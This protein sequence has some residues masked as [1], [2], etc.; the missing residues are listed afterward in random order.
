MGRRPGVARS[1]WPIAATDL[2]GLAGQL[3]VSLG[4]VPFRKPW[5]GEGNVPHNLAV[6]VTRET[7]RSFM[8]YLTAL[9]IDEFRSVELVLDD[10]S[11]AVL[12]PV[13][14]SLDVDQS[15][16]NVAGVPG[17]WY[18]P[19]GAAARGT[20]LYL[21]GGGYVGT[22]PRMYAVFVAWLCRQ[23]GCELFVADLRLAPEFP[24]PAGLEDA[25]LVVEGL[26]AAGTNPDRLFVAGDSSG[27]G[28]AT[29]LMYAMHRVHHR[30][31]AGVML[32]SPE[33]DL[34][35]DEPSVAANAD[36]DI[37]PWNIPTTGYL[38]GR[39]A[40]SAAVSGVNQDVSGWPP[41]LVSFGS[42]EMFRDAIRLFVSHLEEAD[43]DVT[44]LEEPGMFH[45]FPILMPWAEG[46]RRTYR[47]VGEFVRAHLPD[48]PEEVPVGAV[49]GVADES[50]PSS[51]AS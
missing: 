43:V 6:A 34:L 42:D 13:V 39:D 51:A 24:F 14:R 10:L 5:T 23:T 31:I 11:G 37:L 30:P 8:G 50:G 35:L 47:E 15:A 32:F 1:T 28:L 2:V 46:S 3:T 22:S 4:R 38:H 17:I 40:G 12:T 49:G 16:G 41:T 19:R 25:V 7:I 18:R 44:S 29:S 36:Q 20:V 45:V 27:G 21:H 26:L 33:L 48:E 9:P